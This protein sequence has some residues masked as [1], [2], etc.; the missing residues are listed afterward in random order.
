MTQEATDLFAD[1][2][3]LEVQVGDFERQALATGEF[4]AA[5]GLRVQGLLLSISQRIG[6]LPVRGHGIRLQEVED[7]RSRLL[8]I[9]ARVVAVAEV[10]E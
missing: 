3:A 7:L 9:S 5:A 4:P 8:A 1:L 10:R 2:E 6:A